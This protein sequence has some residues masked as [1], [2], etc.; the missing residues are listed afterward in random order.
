MLGSVPD[1]LRLVVVPAFA[2][3][4]WR[5]H[6]TRRLPNRLWYPLVG[7]GVALLGWELWLRAPFAAVADRLFLIRVVVS[8]G[9]VVP[10][11]YAFWRLGGFGGADAKALM[12]LAVLLPTYPTYYLETTALPLVETTLGVFSLTVLSNTVLV[13]LAYPV[14]LT[15]RNALSRDVGPAMFLARRLPAAALPT[16]HGRLFETREGFT[17]RGLDLDALRMYLRWRGSTLAAVR[18]DPTG[19]R[20]PGSITRTYDP[21][22]GAVHAARSDGGEARVRT[23]DDGDGRIETG[24]GSGPGDEGEAAGGDPI[25]DADDPWG[26]EAFL[27]SIDGTAY[28]TTPETLREGLEVV[29]ARR[30]IWVSPGLPFVVPMFLGLLLAFTYGDLLFGALSALG[31]V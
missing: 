25:A 8:V 19:H 3:A 30:E 31:M 20:D 29:A 21:T 5:D 6:R 1:L 12:T 16:A 18:A 15:L 14:A 9:L 13:G 11:S 28:G 22:D 23:A 10:L 26:A 17:R 27:A 4:A 7:L 2:W 24:G